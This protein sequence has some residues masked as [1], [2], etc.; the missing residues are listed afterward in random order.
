MSSLTDRPSTL[1]HL[2]IL[3]AKAFWRFQFTFWA[4]VVLSQIL[5]VGLMGGA[6]TTFLHPGLIIVRLMIGLIMSSVAAV[7]LGWLDTLRLST[8]KFTMATGLLILILFSIASLVGYRAFLQITH[9]IPPKE[10]LLAFLLVRIGTYTLWVLLFLRFIAQSRRERLLHEANRSELA[11]LRSQVNPHFLFNSLNA[12]VAESE[13]PVKVRE[14]TSS[15]SEYLRFSVKQGDEGA[16]DLRSLGEELA[17]LEDYLRIHHIRFEEKLVS[18]IDAEEETRAQLVPQA[19]IQPLL[20]NA[21]NY[22]QRT[23]PL[24]LVIRITAQ[25]SKENLVVTVENSGHWLEIA[26]R[27]S[28][29]TGLRNLR[30]RL[31]L[32]YGS[33]ASLEIEKATQ[34]VRV[35]VTLPVAP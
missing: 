9:E 3:C 21:I 6:P 4:L 27:A 22:G 18:T 31:E 28:T 20:E 34:K 11:L 33:K 10:I 14:I 16:V 30:R 1:S 35:R 25:L 2:S 15:L 19:L 29:G 5:L 23:S 12:I 24:P 13:D 8:V 26:K 7:I 32:I 17:A